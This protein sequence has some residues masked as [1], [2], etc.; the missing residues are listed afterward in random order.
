VRLALGIVVLRSC[1][2]CVGLGLFRARVAAC[3][4]VLQCEVLQCA[5]VG[6]Y[7]KGC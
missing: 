4:S 6:V 5:A 7:V 3:Y 2:V 1:P